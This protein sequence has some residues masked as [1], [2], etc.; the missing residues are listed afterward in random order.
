MTIVSFQ[1]FDGLYQ[2][3]VNQVYRH[4]TPGMQDEMAAHCFGWGRGR[5]DFLAYLRASAQRFYLAY[6]S[7]ASHGAGLSLCD[8]GGFWGV[9]AITMSRL[10][11]RVTMTE[12][13]KYYSD[14]FTELFA[15]ISTQGVTIVDYDPFQEGAKPIGTF[16]ALS[17]MAVLEHYPHSPRTFM[18][19]VTG[20][21][22]P[23]G[24]LYLEV[25]NIAYWPRRV[26][27]LRGISPLPALETIYR[28]DVPFIGH[29]HE[30]TMAELRYLAEVSGLGVVQERYYNYSPGTAPS[31]RLLLRNPLM[32]L[33]FA[34]IEDSRECLAVLC[35]RTD[36]HA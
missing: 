24:L 12:A 8:I 20:M 3:A 7:I 36:S 5:F 29:H 16:D 9:F 19:N 30:Y 4:W 11:Y 31:L 13:L 2:D 27:L 25:P 6:R 35:Q 26:N 34:V 10:G 28:S 17:V 15:Y 1:E 22:Q 32:L 18:A 23:Q 33:A 21:M 14:S